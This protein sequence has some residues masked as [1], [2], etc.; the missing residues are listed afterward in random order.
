MTF[1]TV[2]LDPPWPEHGGGKSKRGADKHY[3][4]VPIGQMYAVISLTPVWQPADNAHMYMW[5]TDNC[6]EPALPLIR[7]LGFRFV[8]TFAWVKL[9]ADADPDAVDDDT[10][11]DSLAMGLGQYARGAHELLLFA[12]RGD[13]MAVRSERRDIGSVIPAVRGRHSAKPASVYELIE[14]RSHG[15]YLEMFARGG[16]EGW[17]SWGNEI[18]G[19]EP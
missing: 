3:P 14:A 12:V 9:K 10:L 17:R 18:T 16:R 19:S 4:L 11:G 6:L 1:A 8:R 5:V 2:Y 13:G 15:P 7:D